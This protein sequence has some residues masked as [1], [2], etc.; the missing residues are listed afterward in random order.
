MLL[1]VLPDGSVLKKPGDPDFDPTEDNGN[2]Y[3]E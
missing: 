1:P 2:P 3:Y